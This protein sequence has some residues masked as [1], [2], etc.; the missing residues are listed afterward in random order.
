MRPRARDLR[1][2]AR[3]NQNKHYWWAVLVTL[4]AMV[5]GGTAFAVGTTQPQLNFNFSYNL[6]LPMEELENALESAFGYGAYDTELRQ[7]M[8]VL[9][10]LAPLLTTLLVIGSM[11]ALL[12]LA[13]IVVAGP[14]RYGY[15]RYCLQMYDAQPRSHFGILFSGFQNFGKALGLYW[16]IFLKIFLWALIAIAGVIVG[17]I[18]VAVI[19]AVTVTTNPALAGMPDAQMISAL[20]PMILVLVLVEYIVIFASLIPAIIAEYRYAMAYY[21]MVEN[22]N[23]RVTDAVRCSAE[24][25]RGNKWRLFC[26]HLSF[27]GWNIL[28]SLTFGILGILF[29]NPYREYA[30]AA[31]YRDLVPAQPVSQLWND[32]PRRP[33]YGAYPG[34]EM[35]VQPHWDVPTEPPQ[36]PTAPTAN[37][38]VQPT[39]EEPFGDLPPASSVQEPDWPEPP[40]A[41][42]N[43]WIQ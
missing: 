12:G 19:A 10:R 43:P 36:A 5:L 41:P 16:W 42:Q 31:F 28:N 6:T 34:Q 23:L 39:P 14:M 40:E 38:W 13:A 2:I 20:L 37:P 4:V 33:V 35:P 17:T 18:L 26:L 30:V 11:S 27:L 1:R 15:S 22:P 32:V 24:L 3:A 21:L 7:V 29:L 9:Q 8:G 25:M